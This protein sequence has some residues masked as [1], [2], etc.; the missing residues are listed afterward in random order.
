MVNEQ[1]DVSPTARY[2]IAEAAAILGMHRNTLRRHTNNGV[3]GIEC[4]IRKCNGRKYY[5]G[6]DIIKF[7]RASM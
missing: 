4:H 3:F 6:L 2:T 1:P 5:T 7:W